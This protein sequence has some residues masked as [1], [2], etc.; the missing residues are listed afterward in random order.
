MLAISR[1]G[2]QRAISRRRSPHL[3]KLRPSRLTE[4][5]IMA[6]Y[7]LPRTEITQIVR[8]ELAN[9][10]SDLQK[11]VEAGLEG[12]LSAIADGVAKAIDQN[13]R[14]MAQQILTEVKRGRLI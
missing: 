11:L 4:E 12:V 2:P 14:R 8:N 1:L 10:P 5:T 6:T 7:G 9:Y 3:G 13:N